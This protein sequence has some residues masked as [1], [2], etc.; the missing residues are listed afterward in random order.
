MKS[1]FKTRNIFTMAIFPCSVLFLFLSIFSPV[2][3][4]AAP[5]SDPQ[6]TPK[7]QTVLDY[8]TKLPSRTDNKII[9][10]QHTE[11]WDGLVE[12][13]HTTT[14]KYA[15]IA[16]IDYHY[17]NSSSG[18]NDAISWWNAGSLIN[19]VAHWN[20]PATASSD[21][22]PS[23]GTGA[24]TAW[25]TTNVDFTQLITN[26]TTLNTN[27]KAY[28]DAMATGFQTLSNAG[29]TV[30]YRPFHEMNGNWFWWGA[31]DPTQFKNVWIY[32]YNYLTKTKGLHNIL[33]V[34]CPNATLDSTYYPGT[35]YVDIVAV[36]I[37]GAG[38]NITGPI[39]GYSSLSTT[40][41][42][43]PFGLGEWGPCAPSGCTSPTDVS[44][45]IGALKT[46]M[47]NTT[48][49]V[50]WSMSFALAANSGSSVVNTGATALLTDP[51][52]IT[53]DDISLTP[54][55]TVAPPTVL[56]VNSIN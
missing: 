51:W 19:V 36:D 30:M 11:V 14:G 21:S 1:M 5:A 16:E 56:R 20:N 53:R 26:G 27:F 54:P 38:K 28:L 46:Y 32:V 42:N 47:P 33:F 35:S 10:G 48:F 37:Y 22:S 4:F 24:G 9:S 43:K 41:N 15:G 17:E 39:A 18:N 31:K 23:A 8:L 7:T 40:F 50:N 52:V 6:A 13:V 29:V 12:S 45:L 49:W 25:D 44:W 3:A 55:P 2:I 34:Y